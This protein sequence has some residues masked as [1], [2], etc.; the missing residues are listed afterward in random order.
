MLFLRTEGDVRLRPNCQHPY[1]KHAKMLLNPKALTLKPEEKCAGLAAHAMPRLRRVDRSSRRTYTQIVT[2]DSFRMMFG[3]A[4]AGLHLN[5][6]EPC[7]TVNY[8]KM[9]VIR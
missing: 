8:R 5:S 4:G 6:A 2:A 9:R 7:R 1:Q 3:A